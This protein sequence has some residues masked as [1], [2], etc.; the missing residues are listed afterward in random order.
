MMARSHSGARV[1]RRAGSVLRGPVHEGRQ[2][3]TQH[4]RREAT[5]V[6]ISHSTKCQYK[7]IGCGEIARPK[8]DI[9][10][11]TK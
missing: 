11:E 4:A 3:D 2:S 7:Y 1:I 6:S 5:L 9:E 10:S 8:S